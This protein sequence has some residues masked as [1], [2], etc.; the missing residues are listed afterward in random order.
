MLTA[1]D[2]QEGARATTGKT[3]RSD[4]IGSRLCP[5]GFQPTVLSS[6]AV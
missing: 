1:M 2:A 3:V 6:L 5:K 4:L